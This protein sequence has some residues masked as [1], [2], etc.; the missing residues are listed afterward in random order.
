MVKTLQERLAAFFTDIKRGGKILTRERQEEL[1]RN[2]RRVRSR[3]YIFNFD[4]VDNTGFKRAVATTSAGWFFLMTGAAV[5]FED[6]T[7]GDIPRVSVKFPM[8]C[9]NGPFNSEPGTLDTVDA[10]LVFG[11]EG[12]ED[13]SGKKMHFEEYKNLWYV[14]GDAFTIEAE[15]RGMTSDPKR[16]AL[17]ITGLEIDFKA[18]GC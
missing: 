9:P 2:A 1:L 18:V 8:F 13:S 5:W 17:V 15:A 14:L 3:D 12:L 11:R 16:G 4:G 7:A 10:G 6:T